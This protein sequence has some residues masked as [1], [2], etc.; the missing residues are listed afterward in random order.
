MRSSWFIIAGASLVLVFSAAWM[1]GGQEERSTAI[2]NPV[3]VEDAVATPDAL[4]QPAGDSSS[5]IREA[6]T[7]E[8]ARRLVHVPDN[9]PSRNV[10]GPTTDERDITAENVDQLV[11]SNLDFA[12]EGGMAS[13][14]F[15]TRTRMTCER[16]TSTPGELE[17][18]IR[19]VN[20][21][22]ENARVRGHDLPFKAEV[23][24]PWSFTDD[25]E[26]NRAHL[27]RW[28]DACQRL[29]D[30]FTPDLRQ[31]LELLALDGNVMARYL[32]ATW[33]EELLNAGEAFDMQYRWEDRAREFSLANMES[34][35]VAGLMAFGQSYMSGWFT[36]RN[37]DLALAFG[38]AALNCDFQTI[39]VR[40][41]LESSIDRLTSSEDPADR[42]RLQFILDESDRLGR[43]CA[44]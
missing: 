29:Q 39:S 43:F 14:Y 25:A 15:V 1:L 35:E 13:G 20:Q 30:I 38:V 42:Q 19:R 31:R 41:Y 8:F 44:P 5:E 28:Y 17:R 16:F 10:P 21:R 3:Q 6:F 4:E 9:R 36:S 26:A 11:Q 12:L 27:E 7:A 18:T 24:Q 33:P 23:D 2:N 37:G 22:V 40:S 34:G 32:Y